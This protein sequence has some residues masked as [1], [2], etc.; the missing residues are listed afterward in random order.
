MR[1]LAGLRNRQRKY[2]VVALGLVAQAAALLLIADGEFSVPL[3][4]RSVGSFQIEVAEVDVDQVRFRPAPPSDANAP[5]RETRSATAAN[6]TMAT[7]PSLGLSLLGQDESGGSVSP[8]VVDLEVA[9]AEIRPVLLNKTFNV[10]TILGRPQYLG[11]SMRAEVDLV[12]IRLQASPICAQAVIADQ[13]V[14]GDATSEATRSEQSGQPSA[15]IGVTAQSFQGFNIDLRTRD[16]T[17][18]NVRFLERPDASF[19]PTSSPD[20]ALTCVMADQAEDAE[21]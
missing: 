15:A 16:L 21:P 3:V 18:G 5:V 20:L 2:T 1:P 9:A 17:V 7:A 12:D 6:P 19:F 4:A 14:V 8:S 10:G 13:I 11:L